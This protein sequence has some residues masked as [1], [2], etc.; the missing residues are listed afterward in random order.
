LFA[1]LAAAGCA[2][3][4]PALARIALRCPDP[5]AELT[6]DGAPA[7]KAGDYAKVRLSLRPG[8]HRFELRSAGGTVQVREVYVGPGD[9]IALEL[10]GGK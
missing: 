9:L 4:A 2:A 5:S 8:Y 10:G 6:V 7:G 3:Q 1:L